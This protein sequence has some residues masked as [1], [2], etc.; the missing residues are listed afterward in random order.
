VLCIYPILHDDLSRIRI[1]KDGNELVNVQH[2]VTASSPQNQDLAAISDLLSHSDVP[3]TATAITANGAQFNSSAAKLAIAEPGEI[4]E[5][6]SDDVVVEVTS[7]AATTFVFESL[8]VSADFT[9]TKL[10]QS[11]VDSSSVVQRKI[12]RKN[13]LGRGRPV[14]TLRIAAE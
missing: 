13:T 10:R 14:Q 3:D 9:P 8:V 2:G 4:G 12:A 6:L 11:K 7:V 1:V 5:F